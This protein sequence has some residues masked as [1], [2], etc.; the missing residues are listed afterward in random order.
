MQILIS[1]LT[2]TLLMWPD[3]A[4]AQKTYSVSVS[5]H[6]GIGAPA[7]SE[8]K[9]KEILAKASE[10]LRKG[11]GHV[12]TPGD[13]AC[14][15]TFTLKGPIRTFGSPDTP[16]NVEESHIDAVHRVDA[17]EP[18]W[19][20]PQLPPTPNSVDFHVKIVSKITNFCRIRSLRGFHG[21]SFPPNYHSII[22][23]HPATHTDPRNPSENLVEFPDHL[24]WA[25]EFGHLAGLGHRVDSPGE[26][27][28]PRRIPLMTPCDLSDKF[29][30]D[31]SNARAV[32]SQDECRCLLSGLGS[33]P[34][35][36]PRGC[37]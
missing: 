1:I 11:F 35:P 10:V 26:L 12:D 33:C 7:L 30:P 20:A 6:S 15:V 14:N 19:Q 4:T 36:A 17:V 37:Q 18:L 32:V 28:T 3:V 34:L 21:C 29:G 23:V 24:L 13:V 25:H 27:M 22:V 31:G 8:A 9:I 16:A 5:Q 2:L